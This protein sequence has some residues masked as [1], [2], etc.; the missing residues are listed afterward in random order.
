[1]K[2]LVVGGGAT[3]SVIVHLLSKSNVASRVALSIWEKARGVGGR[4]S[5]HRFE[6]DALADM[7]AQY[8]TVPWNSNKPSTGSSVFN[9]SLQEL[10]YSNILVP[11]N[12]SIENE[13]SSSELQRNFVAPGGINTIVKHFINNSKAQ[14]SVNTKLISLDVCKEGVKCSTDDGSEIF[15]GVVLTIPLPQVSALQGDLGTHLKAHE[16]V[17]SDAEYSS[18]YAVAFAYK[19]STHLPFTWSSK[20][21]QDDVIRYVSYEARKRGVVE[22]LAPVLMIHTAVPFGMHHLEDDKQE[23]IK[24]VQ[25]R[26]LMLVPGLPPPVDSYCV[27]WRY[28]QVRRQVCSSNGYLIVHQNP[29][30]VLTGDAFTYSNLEGSFKAAEATAR[31]I[32]EKL[33]KET[34][35]T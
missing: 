14:I 5:T 35:K 6:G 15:D 24:T 13:V 28:S 12:G 9:E 32:E 3:G 23:I 18:R 7:G 25:S 26:L 21:F 34:T 8:I 16:K 22:T 31:M 30:V 29:M 1:M 33:T 4:M 10:L 2:L 17:F 11:F 19:R 27:R 20:Y